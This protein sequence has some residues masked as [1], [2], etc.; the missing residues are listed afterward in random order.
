[1]LKSEW[2]FCF[3]LGEHGWLHVNHGNSNATMELAASRVARFREVGEASLEAAPP[4][5]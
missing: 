1:L 5:E 3:P 2:H 4:L